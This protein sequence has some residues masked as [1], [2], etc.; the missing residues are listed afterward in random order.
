MF[1]QQQQPSQQE[2]EEEEQ[3]NFLGFC[4]F[5]VVRWFFIKFQIQKFLIN[6]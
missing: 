1:S 3:P 5:C 4:S 2:E 6:I